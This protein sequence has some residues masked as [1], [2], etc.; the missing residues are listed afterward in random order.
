MPPDVLYV[1]GFD[2]II[3]SID[4]AS[5]R[6]IVEK[7][8]QVAAD[9][10]LELM[11]RSYT[12]NISSIHLGEKFYLRLTDSDRD[13]S[14]KRDKI[15]MT[16]KASSGEQVEFQLEETFVRSGI[17]EGSLLPVHVDDSRDPKDY[18]TTAS[19]TLKIQL[20]DTIN[21]A[22]QDDHRV[23]DLNPVSVAKDGNIKSGADAEL[24]AFSKRFQDKEMAVKTSFLMAESLFEMAKDQRKLR[25]LELADE[26]IQQGK[27]VLEEALRDYPDTSLVARGE[28]LLANLA[29]ELQDYDEAI[30]RYSTVV[31]A[32]PD[33]EYAPKAMFKKALCLEKKGESDLALE[34]YVKL[35]YIYKNSEL[36]ADAVVR[37]ASYYYKHEQFTTSAPDFQKFRDA[38]SGAQTGGEGAGAG[39]AERNQSRGF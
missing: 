4:D 39:R 27:Q 16:A 25:N 8:V 17:F 5:S 12:A 30:R 38:K 15:T 13:A 18:N 2:T 6:T 19:A 32:W 21:F 26:Y 35:T 22:Y 33:S 14:I 34:E 20:G 1:K 37:L 10:F 7:R 23:I 31:T 11:E 24:A 29:Q 9:G 3:L 28:Y 36:A